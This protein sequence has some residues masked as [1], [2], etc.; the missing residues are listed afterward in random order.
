MEAS[1]LNSPEVTSSISG[2][3]KGAS[4]EPG[5]PK[6]KQKGKQKPKRHPDLP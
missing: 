6:K 3:S 2:L 5:A 4:V 1:G